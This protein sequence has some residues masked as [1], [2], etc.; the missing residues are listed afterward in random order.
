LIEF[1]FA[2]NP[3][4]RVGL[5]DQD[6]DDS[7][8][9]DGKVDCWPMGVVGA[10]RHLQEERHI[11][12]WAACN[13]LFFIAGEKRGTGHEPAQHIAPVVLNGVSR[14]NVGNHRWTFGW[15]EKPTG[16]DFKVLHLPSKDVLSRKL[17]FGAAGAQALVQNGKPLQTE[18]F[19]NSL[20]EIKRGAQP[21]TP[22][23]VGHIPT[24]DHMRTSRTSVAWSHDSKKLWLLIVKEPDNET[25]S[26]IEFRHG[27]PMKGGWT[28]AELQQ[29][30][31]SRGAWGAVNFDGGDVTQ[32]VWKLTGGE[33]EFIPARQASGSLR[34]KLPSSLT[35]DPGGGSI[36]YFYVYEV[37]N[38]NAR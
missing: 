35:P 33:Y 9:G 20:D 34:T 36:M 6:E 23:Q 7:T 32:A 5:Y 18:P 25:Q 12:V 2:A 31:I 11:E 17:T 10:V 15:K 37:S 22:N 19:P 28:V 4:L 30:W 16:I 21:S 8:P 26:A 27:E 3:R 1:D 38:S 24:V 14:Y 13:G 29:F